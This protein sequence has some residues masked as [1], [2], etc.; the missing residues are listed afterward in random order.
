MKEINKEFKQAFK[1]LKEFPDTVT[2]F[3]SARFTPDHPSYDQ[4]RLLAAKISSELGCT[5]ISG[6]GSGIMEAAN[7]GAAEVGGDAVAMTIELPHE[8]V[9]NRYV[10]H[11]VDFYYFFSRK[12]ALAFTARAYVYFPGGYGTL[13]EFFEILTLKQTGKIE[14]LPIVL[15]GTDYWKPLL[16]YIDETLLEKY[17]AIS[18]GENMLYTLTDDLDEAYKIIS[19]FTPRDIT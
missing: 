11:S 18:P 17:K 7:R 8:Q 15:I 1:L 16:K 19:E 4:A 14:Q 10:S 13:D 6:G 12:V 2:F 3:G 9:T 5:I